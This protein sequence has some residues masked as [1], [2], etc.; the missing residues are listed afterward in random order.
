[1]SFDIK[2]L[3]ALADQSRIASSA[4]KPRTG[5]LTPAQLEVFA[6]LKTQ[7]DAAMQKSMVHAAMQAPETSGLAVG[8]VPGLSKNGAQYA[9]LRYER[10]ADE[11]RVSGTFTGLVSAVQLEALGDDHRKAYKDVLRTLAATQRQQREHGFELRCDV[12]G[13]VISVHLIANLTAGRA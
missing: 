3:A 2:G 9:K 10:G 6:D 12:Q 4:N 1:M 11:I 7:L 13:L 8:D 5:A